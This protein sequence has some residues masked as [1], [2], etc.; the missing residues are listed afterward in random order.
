MTKADRSTLD[1]SVQIRFQDNAGHRR[2]ARRCWCCDSVITF[3][4]FCHRICCT[5]RPIFFLICTLMCR[6][7][8]ISTSKLTGST[9]S[10]NNAKMWIILRGK[11]IDFLLEG[12]GLLFC[13]VFISTNFPNVKYR[14]RCNSPQLALMVATLQ[15]RPFAPF[16]QAQS[17]LETGKKCSLYPVHCLISLLRSSPPFRAYIFVRCLLIV[18]SVTV[19]VPLT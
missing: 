3:A 16:L 2:G 12:S 10:S 17:L 18:I 1:P 19:N 8:S 5:A 11:Y 4:T 9:F 13:L 15:G 6:S 14:L 7:S